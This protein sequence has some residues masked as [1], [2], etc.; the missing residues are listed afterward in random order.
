MGEKSSVFELMAQLAIKDG[1]APLN[2]HDGCWVRRV[3]EQWTFAINGN[4]EP[5]RC[6][7]PGSMGLDISPFEAAVWFNGWLAA[8][9]GPYEGIFV[10]G[11]CGNENAFM[12]ALEKELSTPVENN[13][14]I[15][16][17]R[18]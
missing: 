6:K 11:S 8:T 17:D 5:Q 16:L 14:Q 10:C 3:D 4:R 2:A 1:A 9:M 7:P 18:A 15:P 13:S 12:A